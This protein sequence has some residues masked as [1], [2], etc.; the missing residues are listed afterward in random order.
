MERECSSTG[1]EVT[2]P[3]EILRETHVLK[4]RLVKL[5]E[6][7][8]AMILFVSGTLLGSHSRL[9]VLLT[10]RTRIDSDKEVETQFGSASVSLDLTS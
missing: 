1:R 8:P 4:L 5:K 9:F 7:L 10:H 2:Y 3:P 6:M